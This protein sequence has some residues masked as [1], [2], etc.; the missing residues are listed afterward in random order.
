MNQSPVN[1]CGKKIGV[2]VEN[3]FIPEEIAAYK[4]A[5]AILG[6]EVEFI[7]RIWYGD[8]KPASVIFY[9]DVDPTDSQPWESPQ[10]LTV[11]RD[12]SQVKPGDYAAVI[13]SANYTS[14]R[15]R[16]WSDDGVNFPYD[17]TKNFNA[18]DYGRKPPVVS[19]FADAMRDKSIVKGA[20]CHGL[21]LLTP[22]P[23]LLEGRTVTCHVVVMADI[24][25]CGAN[26][27]VDPLVVTDDDLVTGFSKHEVLAFIQAIAQRVVEKSDDLSG[28]AAEPLANKPPK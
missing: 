23:E 6:A 25:N 13:M 24:V 27:I 28:L 17:V 9:S 16:W 15:L 10:P 19:F 3:K 18:R 22:N 1:L 11:N 26:V 20:L 8:W 5:F 7:S 12:I 4:S 14:V 21:W 2:I